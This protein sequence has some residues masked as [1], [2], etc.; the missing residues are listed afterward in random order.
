MKIRIFKIALL[1]LTLSFSFR[2]LF[3]QNSELNQLIQVAN[4]QNRDL[5]IAYK[6]TEMHKAQ[7]NTAYDMPKMP[8]EL[9]VG[10]IQNPFVRDYTL[11]VSQ[12]FELPSVYKNKKQYLISL[13]QTA[14]V[15]TEVLKRQLKLEIRMLYSAL[16]SVNSKTELIN[17]ELEKLKDLSRVYQQKFEQG[18]ADQSDFLNIRL[19]ENELA[20][21]LSVYE[22]EKKN[23]EMQLMQVLNQTSLPVLTYTA[24][25]TYDGLKN[26]MLPEPCQKVE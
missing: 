13:G 3:A 6:N 10:N 9:Q 20:R 4:S 15:Q 14:E 7:I 26:T 1:S 5:Q 12:S 18:E 16:T 21:S 24:P 17:Q 25:W 8:V 2:G 11:G 19:K 22:M 23:L